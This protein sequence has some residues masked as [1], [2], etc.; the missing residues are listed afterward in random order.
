MADPRDVDEI[1][2]EY[3]NDGELR[4]FIV[5]TGMVQGVGFRWTTQE[6]ARR[7]GVAGWVCNMS[8]GTVEAEFQGTGETVCKVLEGLRD[9]FADARAKYPLLR[10]MG[11]TFAVA[12]CERRTPKELGD[13]PDFEVRF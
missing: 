1:I 8:D 6:L 7:A 11:L 5:F 4:L 13:K 9:Q 10:R 12:T 3:K 2:Y